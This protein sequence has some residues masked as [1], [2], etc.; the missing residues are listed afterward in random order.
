MNRSLN[1]TLSSSPNDSVGQ[2][3]PGAS[4]SAMNTS[5]APID[6]F[7]ATRTQLFTAMPAASLA[8]L[9]QSLSLPSGAGNRIGQRNKVPWR[10]IAVKIARGENVDSVDS[11]G[12]RDGSTK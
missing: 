12:H 8:V 6:M 7:A 3:G 2:V 4:V 1:A 10:L 11:S 5:Y 9:F